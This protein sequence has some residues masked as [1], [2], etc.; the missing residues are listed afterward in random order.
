MN[1]AVS[2]D[3]QYIAYISNGNLHI[4]RTNGSYNK[5]VAE[6]VENVKPAWSSDDKYLAFLSIFGISILDLSNNRITD[7][8]SID[9]KFGSKIYLIWAPSEY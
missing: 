1:P 7:L 2:H 8:D 9:I 5:V 4:M 6:N 3:G